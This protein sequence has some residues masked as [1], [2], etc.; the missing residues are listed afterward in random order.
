MRTNRA[1]ELYIVKLMIPQL[2]DFAEAKFRMVVIMVNNA[3][4]WV[5]D[6]F[7]ADGEH[8]TS[9]KSEGVSASTHDQVFNV[10]A[11]GGALLIAEFARRHI[12]NINDLIRIAEPE[13][14]AEG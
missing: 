13:K 2:F 5:A 4:G 14:V 8:V 7:T 11:R 1:A 6:T 10:D 3:T 12:K 9:F